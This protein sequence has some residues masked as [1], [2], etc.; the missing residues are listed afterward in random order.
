[1]GKPERHCKLDPPP[2]GA[3]MRD[4]ARH[5]VAVLIVAGL[6]AVPAHSAF[7][8]PAVTP[9]APAPA[10][11][12]R[13]E[14]DPVAPVAPAAPDVMSRRVDIHGFV[15]EGGFLTTA[16]EYIGSSSHGSLELAEV[17]IGISTQLTDR[18]RVGAQLFARDFGAIEDAPRFDWAFL[19][20]RWKAWLGIRAGIIRMPFGLYNEYA[21]VD[22]ARL[23]ILMPQSV[24]SFRNRDVLLSHRGFA[25]YG[26]RALGA[27]GALEYQAWLGT[28]NIPA[29]AL[30]L[31]GGTVN[32]IDTKYVVGAQ[33]FWQAP[34]DGLRIGATALR[35]S[36][37]FDLTLAP[38]S[39]A[40]LI[41]AGLVPPDYQGHIVVSQRPDTLVIGSVEYLHEAWSFAAEYSRAFKRQRTTLPTVIP[42]F[43]EDTEA[44]YAM[45]SYRASTWLEL[46]GY[47][48]ALH[49]DANDR[50]GRDP[51]YAQHFLAFQRDLAATVRL[52][53]N[54]HWLWK[55]EAHAIDGAADLDA[56]SNPRPE[57]YWGLFLLRTTVTF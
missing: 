5:A 51:K 56:A 10:P 44:F 27:A 25:V 16:N 43:E 23:S 57:R 13:D 2:R 35:A 30:V 48:S 40:A 14:G 8:D 28:L 53:V 47:Y 4:R 6:L 34:L 54:D 52:D 29:N 9:P 41:A 42:T 11:A 20:Y 24:Y 49:L 32:R 26:N 33:V 36:I 50:H 15:S 3:G 45:A 18:L 17:G 21:D 39:T 7:A 1:M 46:G 22:S 38:A 19:D 37:D 12:A 31:S 55:L